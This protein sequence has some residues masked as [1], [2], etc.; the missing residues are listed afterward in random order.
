MTNRNKILHTLFF[1]P[2][3]RNN[4]GL[5]IRT[6]LLLIVFAIGIIS[7][8]QSG[9]EHSVG[10]ESQAGEI[11]EVRQRG[12]PETVVRKADS[13][14][15]AAVTMDHVSKRLKHDPGAFT[16][17]FFY[18]HGEFVESTGGYG[19]S[20]LRRVD[21]KSGGIK[22]RQD[23]PANIFGEGCA[24]TPD[25]IVQLTWKN[26]IAYLYDP[27][28]LEEKNRFEYPREGWGLAYDGE[29]LWASDG[30]NRLY[31]LD[32]NNSLETLR[33]IEVKTAAGAPVS[34]LNE[35][36]WVE[37]LILANLFLTNYI[38]AIDPNS[39]V[40]LRKWDLSGIVE[41]ERP[42]H[43]EHVLNGIAHDPVENRLWITGKCWHFVYEVELPDWPVD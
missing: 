40:V 5:H 33:E 30:S 15:V 11:A 32:Y 43:P 4:S 20:S 18:L 26:N 37:D 21:I 19:T 13:A 2:F 12:H 23:L 24:L 31:V 9:R 35:L 22:K 27:E 25:G 3:F 8:V 1:E 10:N 42:R 16:Q 38:V 41:T 6:G 17:G 28:T 34:R 7:Y 29:K 36:A 39:G 14:A